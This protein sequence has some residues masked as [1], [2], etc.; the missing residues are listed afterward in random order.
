[1]RVLFASSEVTPLA[2][3][4]GL[5]DV[6]AALPAAL[7]GLGLDV[8]LVIPGY[9]QA[10]DATVAKG[11]VAN[12]GD[13]LGFGETRLVAGRTP[14]TGLS[15]WLVDCPSLFARGGGP[16]QDNDGR[17]WP[18]NA[19]RFGLFSHAVAHLAAEGIDGWH[20]DL[21]HAND[22]QTGLLPLLL[23]T[24]AAPRPATV[25]TLHNMAFQ[26]IFPLSEAGA[27]RLPPEACT[28]EGCEYHGQL[29]F[30]KTGLRYA[31]RLTT[32]S[33]SYANE[34]SLPEY[35]MGMDGVVRARRRDLTGILNGIDSRV[36]D[37]ATD[38]YLPVNYWPSDFAGKRSCKAFVQRELGLAENADAPLVV[39][40]SRLTEQKM[41]DLLPATLPAILRK[42]GQFALLGQG[43]RSIAQA[44]EALPALDPTRVAVRVGYDERLAHRLHSA[45]DI[46]LAP[47]RY[48]PCGLVQ[49][50]AMRYGA[51]PVVRGV[52]GLGDTV[53]DATRSAV[54]NG[55]ATG[56]VFAEATA[57]DLIAAVERALDLY[58]QP[59]LW[60]K[61]QLRAMTRDF[62]WKRSARRYRAIYQKI[63]EEHPQRRA[64]DGRTRHP[65]LATSG[66]TR[67]PD[68]WREASR[69]AE[70]ASR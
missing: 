53:V 43:E 1:M 11:P 32:V 45:A 29:S 42:G 60:R 33:P 3:T 70:G 49:L 66:G 41:A 52:G 46:M 56:F 37:P 34:I 38:P 57:A 27:L 39:F 21:V 23:A 54:A 68:P 4:G 16:Y 14:D 50:Y 13:F 61:L 64:G 65:R 15:V 59:I 58:A 6:S 18:D 28:P 9:P 35:G 10:M 7:A 8:A 40:A 25:F 26:G 2:K 55:T 24:H 69:Q 19:R 63:A 17:D 36:W 12:L 62:G 5:A 20:A 44:L 22:W 48:E 47:A 31:D 30:L 51:L 67:R